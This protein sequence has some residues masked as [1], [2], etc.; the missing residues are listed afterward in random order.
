VSALALRDAGADGVEAS[1]AV[2]IAE[3]LA[4]DVDVD[5]LVEKTL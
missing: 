5:E 2:S 4:E 1:L 3:L